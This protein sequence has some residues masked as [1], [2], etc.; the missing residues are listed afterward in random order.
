MI[1]LLIY[2]NMAKFKQLR[3]LIVDDC[4]AIAKKLYELISENKLVNVIGQA[5]SV[6]QGVTMVTE[7]NLDV[8]FLDI[9][10]PDG[11]GME[12][13]M[14]LKSI[15]PNVKVIIFSNSVNDLYRKKF[16]EKGS[17]YVLDKSKDFTKVPEIISLII[18]SHE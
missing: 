3:V 12:I 18:E 2:S 6:K 10:L 1:N 17:D 9:N 14:H 13:L 5:K 8:V 16:T 4:L 11:S 7:L 15:K